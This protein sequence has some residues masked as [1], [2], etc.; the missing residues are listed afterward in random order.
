MEHRTRPRRPLERTCVSPAV[1]DFAQYVKQA[2]GDDCLESC[3]PGHLFSRVLHHEC[4]C[5]AALASFDLGFLNRNGSSI[6]SNDAIPLQSQ[7]YCVLSRA[8]TCVQNLAVN[9]PSLHDLLKELA[10]AICV[11]RWPA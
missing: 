10:R 8:T 11:P 5:G 1:R 7:E 2:G 9:L 3:I 4:D 6:E